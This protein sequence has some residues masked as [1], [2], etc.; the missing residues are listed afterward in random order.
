MEDNSLKTPIVDNMMNFVSNA[1]QVKLARSW[2][3]KKHIH[4]AE[5]PDKKIYDLA[6]NNLFS[7]CKSLFKSP[8]MT[9]DEK[10]EL[11]AK[12]IGDDKSDLAKNV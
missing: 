11:L 9:T 10:K 1:D 5:E 12:V 7:I 4:T 2:A 3:D 8:H 6:Q